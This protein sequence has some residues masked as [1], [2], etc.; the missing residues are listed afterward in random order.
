MTTYTVDTEVCLFD[1]DGTIITTIV[2]AEEAWTKLCNQYNVD[3]QELFK[4]SHGTRTVEVLAKFFPMIDNTD[5]KGVH[6]LEADIADN[7]IDTIGIIPGAKELLFALDNDPRDKSINFNKEHKRK[8][9][10]VTSGSPYMATSWF[11]TILKDVGK[12]DVFI[13]AEN[14]SVGKPDP[15][16]YRTAREL[17]SKTWNYKSPCRSV[18]FEDAPVGIKAGKAMGAIAIGITSSYSK[19]TLFNAGADYVVPDLTHV[20][21]IENTEKGHIVLQIKNPLKRD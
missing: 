15:E 7:Y 2:A 6:L 5:N 17:L 4:I 10:I 3:P 14:V 11:S 19:E 18:V 16:G 1:L 8:W 21:V 20:T 9:A 13:T 12:P